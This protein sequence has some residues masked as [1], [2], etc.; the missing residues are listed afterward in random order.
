MARHHCNAPDGCYQHVLCHT[1]Q[2]TPRLDLPFPDATASDP[3]AE[4]DPSLRDLETVCASCGLPHYK[5]SY[6]RDC[7][8]SRHI[9]QSGTTACIAAVPSPEGG[10]K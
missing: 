6:Q 8:C 9:D 2:Y 7:P 1:C 4:N 3:D 5:D 10:S